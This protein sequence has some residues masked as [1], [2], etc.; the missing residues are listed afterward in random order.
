MTQL[1]RGQPDPVEPGGRACLVELPVAPVV[2]TQRRL[3]GV[4]ANRPG[5]PGRPARRSAGGR[6]PLQPESVRARADKAAPMRICAVGGSRE[7]PKTLVLSPFHL[8][9]SG[10]DHAPGRWP[11]SRGSMC[12]CGTHGNV[13]SGGT[14]PPAKTSGGLLGGNTGALAEGAHDPPLMANLGT[15]TNED[16]LA[17]THRLTPTP[18][19]LWQRVSAIPLIRTTIPPKGS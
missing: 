19:Q 6:T 3:P 7:V 15:C 1:V 16:R 14:R 8:P 11:P 13:I 5:E 4:I 12:S 2:D 17:L 10:W 18:R 9:C